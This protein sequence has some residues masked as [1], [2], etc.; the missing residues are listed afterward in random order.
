M[1]MLG[2]QRAL[3]GAQVRDVPARLGKIGGKPV[4]RDRARGQAGLLP[5]V[6]KRL[7]G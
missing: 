4:L 2:E 7:S 5:V 6:D 1:S 3:D